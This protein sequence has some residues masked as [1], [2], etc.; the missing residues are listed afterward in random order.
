MPV[1]ETDSE[2]YPAGRFDNTIRK[3]SRI[4]IALAVMIASGI[5]GAAWWARGVS[6]QLDMLTQAVAQ[7]DPGKNAVLVYRVEQLEATV[8]A[9]RIEIAALR[10]RQP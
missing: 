7:Y 9:Q 4:E 8:L 10:Q 3:S 5:I 6:G 1:T 2:D